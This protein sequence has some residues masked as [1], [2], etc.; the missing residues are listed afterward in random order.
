[1]D[2]Y[3]QI[4]MFHETNLTNEQGRVMRP[5]F[6]A[7]RCNPLQS[8]RVIRKLEANVDIKPDFTTFQEKK[9]L[10]HAW[11]LPVDGVVCAEIDSWGQPTDEIH[12]I[13]SADHG[14]GSFRANISVVFISQGKV[15]RVKN[16]L[17]GN[18]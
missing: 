2:P 6:N 16:F 3:R 5:F 1:M 17:V 7:D 8:E 11:I 13:F 12:V 14:Q 15:E 18:V 9:S 10:K 4:A